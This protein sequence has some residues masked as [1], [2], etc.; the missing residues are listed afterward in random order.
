[1]RSSR[2]CAFCFATLCI[3]WIVDYV[4]GAQEA[5][6]AFDLYAIRKERD[7]S[8]REQ[9]GSASSRQGNRADAHSQQTT[10]SQSN[11]TAHTH[12]KNEHKNAAPTALQIQRGSSSSTKRAVAS[13]KAAAADKATGKHKHTQAAPP[14][15]PD[16]ADAVG[17]AIQTF[18]AE[19]SNEEDQRPETTELEL[20]HLFAYQTLLRARIRAWGRLGPFDADDLTTENIILRGA[21]SSREHLGSNSFDMFKDWI[22]SLQK[23]SQTPFG[24]KLKSQIWAPQDEVYAD[25]DSLWKSKKIKGEL[26]RGD[27]EDTGNLG[28]NH[29]DSQRLQ[30]L[31]DECKAAGLEG[32]ALS[33]C[34]DAL[35]LSGSANHRHATCALVGNSQR[36]LL[37]DTGGMSI[38]SHDVVLRINGAHNSGIH[39]YVGG[40]TTHRLYTKAGI[41][42]LLDDELKND[43]IEGNE[44]VIGAT[45]DFGLYFKMN[46]AVRR[47][48]RYAHSLR[49]SD[50]L[51]QRPAHLLSTAKAYMEEMLGIKYVGPT[52]N[53]SAGFVSLIY[54]VQICDVVNVYG[55]HLG[56][57]VGLWERHNEIRTLATSYRYYEE[58]PYLFKKQGFSKLDRAWELEHDVIQIFEGLGLVRHH[59]PP[60]RSQHAERDLLQRGMNLI[61]EVNCLRQPGRM[62]SPFRKMCIYE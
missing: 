50:N 40:K 27:V 6:A 56:E 46:R 60:E 45:D 16:E 52:D 38:D 62:W 23:I 37:M 17:E 42:A 58:N 44:T 14:S 61:A 11:G 20:D 39:R 33:T 36:L 35:P 31:N 55:M 8:W 29:L 25:I 13:G 2:T 51:L 49:L 32:G 21:R 9:R 26:K 19:L 5:H 47:S 41:L 34:I 57:T 24:D 10:S 3:S 43:V 1:M 4:G 53:P 12:L 18:Q 28:L 30:A 15:A 54:L 48:S 59:L 7:R 22:A